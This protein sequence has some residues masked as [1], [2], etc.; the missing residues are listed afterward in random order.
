MLAESTPLAANLHVA[1]DEPVPE[2]EQKPMHET[3]KT[4]VIMRM[5]FARRT[6]VSSRAAPFLQPPSHRRERCDC[7]CNFR[8]GG[9]EHWAC[10]QKRDESG[11]YDAAVACSFRGFPELGSTPMQA[12]LCTDATACIAPPAARGRQHTLS[13]TPPETLGQGLS[14]PLGLLVENE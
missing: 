7:P 9:G 8:S 3:Q 1:G 12:W 5:R 11:E 6:P 4:A 14:H 2:S 13:A 10:F